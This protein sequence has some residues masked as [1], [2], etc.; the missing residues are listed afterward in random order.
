MTPPIVQLSQLLLERRDESQ[1]R[2]GHD[3]RAPPLNR[4]ERHHVILAFTWSLS[5]IASF[6]RS[7][8]Y[9]A[10]SP[11]A[12]LARIA[13]SAAWTFSMTMTSS[14]SPRVIGAIAGMLEE[15]SSLM[16]GI[17]W[18]SHQYRCRPLPLRTILQ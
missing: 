6:A 4:E 16:L 12:H 11:V 3:T 18:T 15:G 8:R 5:L 1:A 13:Q 10:S 14:Q 7:S 2:D 9:S 17:I